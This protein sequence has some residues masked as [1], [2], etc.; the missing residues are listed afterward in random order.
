VARVV[1]ADG[2][3]YVDVDAVALLTGG[4]ERKY[5]EPVALENGDVI[6]LAATDY[7]TGRGGALLFATLDVDG[8]ATPPIVLS[9]ADGRFT[10]W[11]EESG[12]C[13]G[14]R[15]RPGR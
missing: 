1:E 3:R 2:N 5:L 10:N 11:H 12:R 4:R 14:R 13:P 15:D 9:A 6:G 8:R 7:R